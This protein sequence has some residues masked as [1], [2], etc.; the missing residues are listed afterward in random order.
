MFFPRQRFFC[1]CT[2]ATIFYLFGILTNKFWHDKKSLKQMLVCKN[3][4]KVHPPTYSSTPHCLLFYNAKTQRAKISIP[5]R[6]D[7]LAKEPSAP[8]RGVVLLPTFTVVVEMWLV[9]V[10]DGLLGVV[11]V[12][13]AGIVVTSCCSEMVVWENTLCRSRNT[14]KTTVALRPSILHSNLN[15]RTLRSTRV[16]PAG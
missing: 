14:R 5:K 3:T 11:D 4:H 2:Q 9:L 10:G 1:Y 7:A 13:G 12:D 15:F 16:C 8:L 6:S